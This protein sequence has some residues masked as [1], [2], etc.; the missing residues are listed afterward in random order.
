[1]NAQDPADLLSN[2]REEVIGLLFNR[3]VFRT[4]QEI[5]RLNS[6]LQGRPRSIFSEWAHV[7]YAQAAAAGVR[8]LAGQD[9]EE[10][11]VNLVGLLELLIRDP[12]GLWECFLQHFPE[13]AAR[14]RRILEKE[15]SL[16]VD[17]EASAC[18]RLLGEDR[19]ALIS[20]A[21][22]AVHF[23]SKRVAH[24]V[25]DVPVT[26]TFNDLDQAI[27]TVKGIAEK[28][29]RLLFTKRLRELE[30]LRHAGKDNGVYG[31]VLQLSKHIDLLDE[32]K[33][34]K[35]QDGWKEI[36]MEPWASREDIERPLGDTRPPSRAPSGV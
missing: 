20:A 28:Y 30:P 36:F 16:P 34:R 27:D 4:H 18:K 2:I 6:R 31:W 1:M 17:W 23:A 14:A 12:S 15:G 19:R 8:R 11:D 24:S 5:V 10:G 7:V 33:R 26:T 32:M 21:Q 25:P 22:E 3:Y 29:T 9:P 13:D 35:L